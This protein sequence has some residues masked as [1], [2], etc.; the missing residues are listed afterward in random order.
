MNQFE[1]E[2]EIDKLLIAKEAELERLLKQTKKKVLSH[3]ADMYQKYE[4][5]GELTYAEMQRYNRLSKELR[6]MTE[7]LTA[8]YQQVVKSVEEMQ[9]EHYLLKFLLT[10]YLVDKVVS[11]PT[12]PSEEIVQAVFTFIT[13]AL[14]LPQLSPGK[15][16]I[17]V[18]AISRAF[19][20]GIEDGESKEDLVKIIQEALPEEMRENND[21]APQILEALIERIE[22]P[23]NVINVKQPT[24]AEVKATVKN[25]DPKLSVAKTF[26]KHRNFVAKGIEDEISEGLKAG[27]G[28]SKVAKRLEERFNMAANKARTVARTES[29]RVRAVAQL[30]TEQQAEQYAEFT[31]LWLSALDARVRAKHR[32]LDGKRADGNGY[33][34]YGVWKAKGPHLW[35]IAEMD[36]NC[37]CQK[38]MLVN[39]MIPEYRRGRDYTNPVYQQKLADRIEQFMANESLTY[40][41]ALKKAQKEIQPPSRVIPYV[42]YQDWLKEFGE[43]N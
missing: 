22:T 27:E 16:K 33:F 35:G 10:A 19:K 7:T 36:I 37:R 21:V 14:K 5:E 43:R 6:G 34:H 32:K 39:N 1:I 23:V 15:E 2:A 42:S 30:E 29:G 11:R 26:T 31:S 41:Q 18:R 40:K 4:R 17:R 38:L 20:W 28:Y 25:E 24:P 12:L 9:Q 3:L 13:S 8:G